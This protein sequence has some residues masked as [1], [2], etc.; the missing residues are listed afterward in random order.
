[1]MDF[2]LID[3]LELPHIHEDLNEGEENDEQFEIKKIL[4]KF[5]L[6]CSCGEEKSKFYILWSNRE[7]TCEDFEF[8]KEQSTCKEIVQYWEQRHEKNTTPIRYVDNFNNEYA[9]KTPDWKLSGQK[10]KTLMDSSP[11]RK[12]AVRQIFATEENFIQDKKNKNEYIIN[13]LNDLNFETPVKTT[14][15]NAINNELNCSINT[16]EEEFKFQQ[17]LGQAAALVDSFKEFIGEE[18]NNDVVKISKRKNKGKST[19]TSRKRRRMLE[20]KMEVEKIIFINNK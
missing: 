7:K 11:A 4:T 8:I 6:K 13:K 9:L 20:K 16:K 15:K 1:M 12:T 18:E 14:L 5:K 2:D 19:H 10:K 3:D 17:G